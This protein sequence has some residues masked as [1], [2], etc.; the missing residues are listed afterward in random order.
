MA[1]IDDVPGITVTVQVNGQDATEYTDPHPSE[2]DRDDAPVCPVCTKFIEAIDDTVFSVTV[3]VDDKIYAWRDVE[4]ILGFFTTVDGKLRVSK[5][6]KR[7]QP[8]AVAGG[9]EWLVK[10]SGE[11]YYKPFKFSRI[12]TGTNYLYDICP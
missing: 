11:T 4:H 5:G 1:V 7:G 3:A 2:R 9:T 10:N 6:L 12:N 8:F